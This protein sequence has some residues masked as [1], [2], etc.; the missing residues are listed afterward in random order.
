MTSAHLILEGHP[1]KH[2]INMLH[3]QLLLILLVVLMPIGATAQTDPAFCKQFVPDQKI[4]DFGTIQEK[5]G[6]VTH[7]FLLTNTSTKSIVISDVKAWCSCTSATFTKTPV[8]PGRQARVVAT[9][10]PSY[11]PGK[12]SKELVVLLNGGESYVR[13]WVKGTV[14]PMQHPVTED[15]PYHYG[16]GL[17]MSHRVLPFRALKAGEQQT[18]Q[19][20]IANDTDRP[21]NIEFRRQPDNRLLQ[22]PRQLTLKPRERRTVDVSYKAWREYSYRRRIDVVPV[23]N[24]KSLS[25]LRLTLLPAKQWGK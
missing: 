11:R 13:L 6:P 22:M 14:V 9:F 17:Y 25:P 23:V 4:F 16:E 10:N 1:K 21:M 19:L 24:G 3:K 15:H 12:F 8:A 18:F 7:T 5:N 2:I 20:R